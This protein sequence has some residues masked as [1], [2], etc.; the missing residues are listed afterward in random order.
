M[1]PSGATWRD[2]VITPTLNTPTVITQTLITPTI[3]TP[4][5]NTSTVTDSLCNSGAFSNPN[6]VRD[7][8]FNLKGAWFLSQSRKLFSYEAL[9]LQKKI[10]FHVDLIKMLSLISFVSSIPVI[11]PSKFRIAKIHVIKSSH[12]WATPTYHCIR[13]VRNWVCWRDPHY[14]RPI[15]RVHCNSFRQKLLHSHSVELIGLVI[16]WVFSL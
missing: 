13:C 8:P 9:F 11:F 16:L 2:N 12:S 4:T 5:L 14:P 6:T 3:I 7:C 10:L 1:W 15:L